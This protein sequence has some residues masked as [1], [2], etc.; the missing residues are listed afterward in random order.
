MQSHSTNRR[1]LLKTVVGLDDGGKHSASQGRALYSHSRKTTQQTDTG[2]SFEVHQAQKNSRMCVNIRLL[3][4]FL[5]VCWLLC[6]SGHHSSA[7]F[8]NVPPVIHDRPP[9]VKMST[10]TRMSWRPA[11]L[12]LAIA[13]NSRC[14]STT[15]AWLRHFHV[16]LLFLLCLVDF[17]VSD[18]SCSSFRSFCR[19]GPRANTLLGRTRNEH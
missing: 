7:C 19:L 17:V 2:Q 3:P 4:S 5:T 8:S 9:S 13:F 11:K 18:A 16:L 6:H 10:F 12:T 15:K 14:I 1:K